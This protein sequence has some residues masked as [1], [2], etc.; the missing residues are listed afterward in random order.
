MTNSQLLQCGKKSRK[1]KVDKH[2]IEKNIKNK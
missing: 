1:H 2:E